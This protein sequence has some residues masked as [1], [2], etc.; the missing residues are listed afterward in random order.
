[1]TLTQR[2]VTEQQ[3]EAVIQALRH[4]VPVTEVAARFRVS[5]QSVHTWIRRYQ[6]DGLAGLADRSHRPNGCPH[7][8]PTD[9]EARVPAPQEPPQ[10][11]TP[12]AAPRTATPLP[13]RRCR[14]AQPC[15]DSS[16]VAG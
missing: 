6:T 13:S 16:S 8:V 11:G 3:Y 2:S 9:V 1:M 15:T 10:V 14:H 5:R 12:T 4:Q 7:Q